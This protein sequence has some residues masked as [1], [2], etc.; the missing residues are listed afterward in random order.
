VVCAIVLTLGQPVAALAAR[1]PTLVADSSPTS[2]SPKPATTSAAKPA[3]APAQSTFKTPEEASEA[4]ISAAERYDVEAMKRVLGPDGIDLVISGDAVQ[5]EKQ[6][7]DFAAQ[8]REKTTIVKNPKNPRIATLTI[9]SEDWPMPIP[10]VESKGQWR[11]DTKAG[12]QEVLFRRIGRNEL[13]AIDVCRGYVEAQREY[14]LVP[15]AP[16]PN[17]YAQRIISTPGKKDGLAWQGPDGKWDGPV[18]EAIAR[19][20]A[21]GYSS[22]YQPYHGYFFKILKGQGQAAPLG[23]MDFVVN[24]MM[25]GGFAL[26][27]SP[28]EYAVSGVKSFIVSHDGI[29]YEKDLGP[30]T[31][32][33]FSAMERYNPDKT[34][35]S[36][37]DQ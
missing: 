16:G 11:F 2:P 20:I 30:K 29:V 15:H 36:V 10:I 27:A 12:R 14:A 7:R 37:E 33:Q 24:G 28:A 34:W 9:G 21:E 18:G 31:L 4:L 23:E 35:H 32:E 6:S 17:Q 22:K 8:A 25:I 19:V 3:A 13:D 26:V 1:G 5:D